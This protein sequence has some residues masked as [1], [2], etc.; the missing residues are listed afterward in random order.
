MKLTLRQRDF[1][2]KF[3]E[4]YRE[5]QRPLH[6]SFIARKLGIAK[7]TAYEMLCALEKVGLVSREYHPQKKPGRS[8][9]K[10]LP[11]PEA[12]G[13]KTL[14]KEWEDVRSLI[15][16]IAEKGANYDPEKLKEELLRELPEDPSPLLFM[17]SLTAITLLAFM[18]AFRKGKV[19]ELSSLFKALRSPGAI[20]GFIVGLALA[21]G[22][23]VEMIRQSLADLSAEA[24]QALADFAKELIQILTVQ[25]VSD[26]GSERF[27]GK[28]LSDRPGD[29][30]PGTGEIE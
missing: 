22:F 10:F 21:R 18:E 12:L 27:T 8:T 11:S 23:S 2:K 9:V 16:K 6:Y 17:A 30:S 7:V 19:A 1:L 25:E 28:E 5:D 13:F 4:L 29:G 26:E 20:T 24:H 3:L 15:S 14:G